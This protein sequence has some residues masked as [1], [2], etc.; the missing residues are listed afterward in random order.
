MTTVRRNEVAGPGA[1]VSVIGCVLLFGGLDVL[2]F[3]LGSHSTGAAGPAAGL[4]LRL[5]IDLAVLG[6]L[7]FPL[8]LTWLLVA[9]AVAMQVSELVAPGLLVATPVLTGDPLTP[10]PIGAVIFVVVQLHNRRSTW[11]LVGVLTLL[12]TRPWDPS[13]STIP[14]G[15]LYTAVPAL[16]G[17]YLA[18]RRTVMASLREKAERTEREQLLLA[19][20]ARA[21]E[22]ARLAAEM[23]DI[24]TH[25]VS[26]MVLQA[27][28]LEVTATEPTV[29][30]A[31]EALRGA[32]MQALD[33]LRELVGVLGG[34]QPGASPQVG[35]Q[36][37]RTDLRDLVDASVAAGVPVQLVVGGREDAAPPVV[38]RTAHRVVQEA[39]TNVHKHAPG[40]QVRV[41]VRYAADAVT[42]SVCNTASPA[43][44]DPALAATGSGSGL[45]GL[46]ERV[47]VIGGAL[48]AAPRPDGGFEVR[49]ELP[50]GAT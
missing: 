44:P 40:G 24:V 31:A 27:G 47:E 28:A 38:L 15:L 1:I 7:R 43:G 35:P 34:E 12:A 45:R 20:Q 5:V 32:G 8:A 3:V 4:V 39:L 19:E 11:L 16:G 6:V 30:R 10:A 41:E 37:P 49:A 18:A 2:V 23:H 17:R 46:R 26:L 42:V 48:H 13:W 29:R 22:R 21:D 50:V 36:A 14:L 9:G 33:E 25:R